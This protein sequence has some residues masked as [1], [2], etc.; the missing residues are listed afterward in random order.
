MYATTLYL[1][2][3]GG[4]ENISFTP[5]AFYDFL[6]RMGWF[7]VVE[8]YRLP[9]GHSHQL[10]DA[11]FSAIA[12]AYRKGD[13]T[14]V[15]GL[16]QRLAAVWDRF[17]VGATLEDKIWN[18]IVC[19]QFVWLNHVLDF[20][21]LFRPCMN[22]LQGIRSRIL[23]WRFERASPQP[24]VHG[25]FDVNVFYMVTPALDKNNGRGWRGCNGVM[26]NDKGQV[27]EPIKL[28]SPELLDSAGTNDPRKMAPGSLKLSK[29]FIC[30]SKACT[31]QLLTLVQE[32]LGLLE[33]NALLKDDDYTA[34][35]KWLRA[36]LVSGNVQALVKYQH[37]GFEDIS[38]IC[39]IGFIADF[40]ENP[41][42]KARKPVGK[43]QEALG[44][45]VDAVWFDRVRKMGFWRLPGSSVQ[46]P[47]S[48]LGVPP[49]AP[50]IVASVFAGNSAHVPQGPSDKA[51]GSAPEAPRAPVGSE[52]DIRQRIDVLQRLDVPVVGYR[53]IDIQ[54]AEKANAL[55]ASSVLPGATPGL[56]S[57]KKGE[58]VF[59]LWADT[60]VIE[61]IH[62]NRAAPHVPGSALGHPEM[63]NIVLAQC[64]DV[65][66]SENE[67]E[68][69]RVDV[70][71]ENKAARLANLRLLTSKR[72]G[73]GV[74]EKVEEEKKLI[75]EKL[76]EELVEM[77]LAVWKEKKAADPSFYVLH[78]QYWRRKTTEDVNASNFWGPFEP[79]ALVRRGNS[80]DS[81][82]FHKGLIGVDNVFCIVP[83]EAGRSS[84]PSGPGVVNI[85]EPIRRI[86]RSLPCRG[87]FFPIALLSE[88]QPQAQRPEAQAGPSARSGQKSKAK[89]SDSCHVRSKSRTL[90]VDHP[91]RRPIGGGKPSSVKVLNSAPSSSDSDGPESDLDLKSSESESDSLT[92]ESSVSIE[93]DVGSDASVSE[94]GPG[95]AA[96]GDA[97]TSTKAGLDH[98][99]PRAQ[100][101]DAVASASGP[102]GAAAAGP[103]QTVSVDAPQN[104]ELQDV[105]VVATIAS[106]TASRAARRVRM[107]VFAKNR[108]AAIAQPVPM[109]TL[110]PAPGLSHY[111]SRVT[112]PDVESGSHDQHS[113]SQIYE[114][115]K[116]AEAHRSVDHGAQS[117]PQACAATKRKAPLSSRPDRLGPGSRRNLPGSS[118]AALRGRKRQ[119]A[120]SSRELQGGGTTVTA[121]Q[122]SEDGVFM[123]AD[124]PRTEPPRI[125]ANRLEKGTFVV[126]QPTQQELE[127]HK[128]RFWVGK[129]VEDGPYK[130]K[131]KVKWMTSFAS[132]RDKPLEFGVYKYWNP[133][134]T[135]EIKADDVVYSFP[136]LSKRNKLMKKDETAICKLLNIKL[137][138]TCP[139][140]DE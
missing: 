31:Y 134:D 1:Q 41:A 115:Y 137:D 81:V 33:K 35:Y 61:F 102:G 71:Q 20:S 24:D 129:L 68:A 15:A 11:F 28:F 21:S 14:T 67:W 42:D 36:Y 72:K 131:Y 39:A 49:P 139:S 105:T 125:P 6:V 70:A 19:P 110:G 97:G 56:L 32:Y 7:H 66:R 5:F 101:E 109:S 10:I 94:A 96:E 50:R 100:A 44:W 84:R 122:T 17:G 126:I 29:D 108:P 55:E 136:S 99:H 27:M 114:I 76:A 74:E 124:G 38:K 103:V 78:V 92:E 87:G 47:N 60:T 116:S 86:V 22:H 46:R 85:K 37:P 140:D 106:G 40:A 82:T 16:I 104:S 107:P 23:A 95:R 118:S 25:T 90:L 135:A 30:K 80:L 58:W 111:K 63:E 65:I 59:V 123:T 51:S 64:I 52:E 3:D 45:F 77:N 138:Q 12:R 57:I 112:V 89:R 8:L 69:K 113:S 91:I 62:G 98:G 121:S 75:E 53:G 48:I 132:R 79:D 18:D 120:G 26:S 34:T 83:L 117:Q 54:A 130:G 119:R 128:F 93:A 2:C 13:M 127:E 43:H 9:V 133:V 73:R 88:A 4:S